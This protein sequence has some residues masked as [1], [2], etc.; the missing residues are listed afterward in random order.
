MKLSMDSA[1][2][3]IEDSWN[4]TLDLMQDLDI[5]TAEELQNTARVCATFHENKG[6]SKVRLHLLFFGGA[7]AGEHLPETELLTYKVLHFCRDYSL[8]QGLDM[9]QAKKRAELLSLAAQSM[10]RNALENRADPPFWQEVFWTKLSWIVNDQQKEAERLRYDGKK[11]AGGY[12]EVVLMDAAGSLVKSKSETLPEKPFRKDFCRGLKRML[13]DIRLHRKMV[14]QGGR[15]DGET[16]LAAVSP[17]HLGWINING[18][19]DYAGVLSNQD[20][21]TYGNALMV[22]ERTPWGNEMLLK[23]FSLVPPQLAVPMLAYLFFSVV[24]P[25]VKDYPSR[26]DIHKETYYA[27]RKKQ[28]KLIFLSLYGAQADALAD[29]FFGAFTDYGENNVSL[30]ENIRTTRVHD[31]VVVLHAPKADLNTFCDT[32]LLRDACV[33]CTNP[34]FEE[35]PQEIRLHMY[36]ELTDEQLETL[37]TLVR[38]ILGNFIEWMTEYHTNIVHT[39]AQTCAEKIWKVYVKGYRKYSHF[40]NDYERARDLREMEQK[41]RAYEIANWYALSCWLDELKLSFESKMDAYRKA[42][43]PGIGI[44]DREFHTEF[45]AQQREIVRDYKKQHKECMFSYNT[46]GRTDKE[47]DQRFACLWKALCC[48]FHC[49]EFKG[50]DSADVAAFSNRLYRYLEKGLKDEAGRPTVCALL[51]EYIS[52][53]LESEGIIPNRTHKDRIKAAGWYD[54]Q[55]RLIYLPYKQFQ[56]DF[57]AYCSHRGI[58]QYNQKQAFAEL[59]EAGMLLMKPNGPKSGYQRADC[60]VVVTPADIGKQKAEVVLKFAVDGLSLSELAQ[61]NLKQMDSTRAPRRS[62]PKK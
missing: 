55:K 44:T 11:I 4:N 43:T 9:K 18:F 61:T 35:S 47:K 32:E 46:F 49:M 6:V 39:L 30:K 41:Y 48:F 36:K 1:L 29:A 40:S 7:V 21:P 50:A 2:D 33:V 5:R 60:K 17:L 25:F 57:P 51:N 27:I 3:W 14:F 13:L 19:T 58:V 62:R 26:I 15:I 56:E 53:L 38:D 54:S 12:A 52:F 24:K 8:I 28:Q 23:L 42:G 37:R 22:Q 59:A 45:L 10:I 16:A 34:G 20:T 31:G